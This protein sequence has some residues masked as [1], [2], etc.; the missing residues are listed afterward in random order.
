MRPEDPR[1]VVTAPGWMEA[2]WFGKKPSLRAQTDPPSWLF[3]ASGA[4][5]TF[6]SN[7]ANI[8]F[9]HSETEGE[10]KS[11]E[12]V[13]LGSLNGHFLIGG[14]RFLKWNIEIFG[15]SPPR[16]KNLLFH[17]TRFIFGSVIIYYYVSASSFLFK[18]MKP[19]N[20]VALF[21]L[22]A[23]SLKTR[24]WFAVGHSLSSLVLFV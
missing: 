23:S 14:Y 13:T 2:K 19:K 16:F 17:L 24:D 22:S 5:A 8:F 21:W 7:I 6:L 3:R 4:F 15:P 20:R 18:I 9:P 12:K 11:R 1:L 10:I